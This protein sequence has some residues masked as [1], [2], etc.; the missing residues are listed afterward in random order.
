MKLQ[1]SLEGSLA[2]FV[3]GRSQIVVTRTTKMPNIVNGLIVWTNDTY[4]TYVD[5]FPRSRTIKS[6]TFL[7]SNWYVENIPYDVIVNR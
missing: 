3:D 6:G 2:K 4:D 5:E 1:Y 7:A